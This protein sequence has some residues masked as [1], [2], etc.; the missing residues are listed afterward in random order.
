MEILT[1]LLLRGFIQYNP[2]TSYEC[3]LARNSHIIIIYKQ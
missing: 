3:I 2:M 1:A